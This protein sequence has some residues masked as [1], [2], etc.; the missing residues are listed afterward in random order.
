M[1]SDK[2]NFA[3]TCIGFFILFVITPLGLALQRKFNKKLK[4]SEPLAI[5]GMLW[6]QHFYATVFGFLALLT[7]GLKHSF[8]NPFQRWMSQD[9]LYWFCNVK[10]W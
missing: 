5:T 10:Q 1:V 7:T 9:Q 8:H 2:E 4:E 3:Q 6:V